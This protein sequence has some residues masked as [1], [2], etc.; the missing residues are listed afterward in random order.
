MWKIETRGRKQSGDESPHSKKGADSN[1]FTRSTR[2]RGG[3]AAGKRLFSAPAVSQR[4]TAQHA[5]EPREG[6]NSSQP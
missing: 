4:L 5:A 1:C 6:P 3:V 2:R